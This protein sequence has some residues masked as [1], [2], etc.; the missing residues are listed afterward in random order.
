MSGLS[1]K[2]CDDVPGCLLAS[3][4]TLMVPIKSEKER[5]GLRPLGIIELRLMLGVF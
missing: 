3:R 5:M 1:F 4:L 2:N